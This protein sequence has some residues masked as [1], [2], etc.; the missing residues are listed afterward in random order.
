MI[1][2]MAT[3]NRKKILRQQFTRA[4][5]ISRGLLFVTVVA[6]S[7]AI[8]LAVT[9]WSPLVYASAS[10][11]A[12][13][14]AWFGG[15][16]LARYA[17][18]PEKLLPA[19][20]TSVS[21]P[22][23]ITE[24]IIPPSVGLST[25][26]EKQPD[27]F[28][29][30]TEDS[31]DGHVIAVNDRVVFINRTARNLLDLPEKDAGDMP[32]PSILPENQREAFRIQ[33]QQLMQS[34]AKSNIRQFRLHPKGRTLR[35]LELV[36]RSG[37]FETHSAVHIVLK[38]ITGQKQ[39]EAQLTE[40]NRELT[41]VQSAGMA[42]TSR[43]DLRYVLNTVAQEMVRLFGV[44]EC[45][46]FEWQPETNVTIQN[47]GFGPA[48][49]WDSQSK[50]E[51]IS[52]TDTPLTAAVL[53]DQI[54]E[55]MI[56]SQFTIDP[57]ER[58]D[59]ARR[60]VKTRLLLPMVYQR[61]TLG[62]I[63]LE[64]FS[65][66]RIFSYQ[67][68]SLAKL[69]ASQ[70]ASAIEN[71]RLFEQAQD[72]IAIRK[73]AE[74]DL[75]QER[76]LLAE[77][78]KARTIEL[79]KAN[80]ELARAARLKDE[81][82]ASMSHELRT[83]LNTIL[84][85]SEILQSEVFGTL[86]ERQQRYVVNIDESGRH[87]LTLINDILDLS[88]IEAGE[89]EVSIGPVSVQS[90]SQASLR[91][92]KQLAH[93]KHL[94]LKADFRNTVATFPADE[95]RVKQILVNLLSNA[96]KF[97]PDG[98][99][100]GLDVTDDVAAEIIH[101]SVWDTGIGISKTDMPRLFQPFVQLDSRLA[102][103]HAGTG[104]GLSLVSKMMELHGGGVSVESEVDGGSRFTV[105]F[106]LASLAAETQTENTAAKN[107]GQKITLR[108]PDETSP[109]VLLAEDN[110]R[111]IGLFTDYLEMQGYRSVV[112]RNGLEAVRR[113]KE[114][115]PDIILMDIQ[116]PEMDGLE[117]MRHL[118]AE[119]AFANVPIVAMTA[120]AMPGDRERCFTAGANEYLIKPINLQFMVN[121][122]QQLLNAL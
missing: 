21:P 107:G 37:L 111:S 102:R 73:R 47:A 3:T 53:R 120:L 100:V 97:T 82:L 17:F 44:G 113:A 57:I 36:C 105:S 103:Q 11:L 110:E 80:A 34:P 77:R 6:V 4:I 87:L 2:N 35:Y 83:P 45:T 122:I 13:G 14:V 108:Q 18:T 89:M 61:L 27:N 66:E 94:Q 8:A 74:A 58:V 85:S 23:P 10:L 117:A 51:I 78:V 71:A 54:P 72:E 76:A 9:Q 30:L 59:M 33:L 39:I 31:H 116:M 75:Q 95:R 49:W 55:Q 101:F 69:L 114:E 26:T 60:N 86:E 1:E 93:K 29:Q 52:L 12:V 99:E 20:D 15:A 50:P 92:V 112:A 46:I 56:I 121:T 118:R 119:R 96:I 32:L 84:G 79:S 5:W 28:R 88:K 106:P 40:R 38:D 65:D 63:R 48:G 22:R 16:W 25:V 42:I 81:F 98:G 43:L 104:L 90:V 62:L 68:I 7:L 64:D 70:A 91:L 24:K 41:I 109:I 115:T 19:A 67:E